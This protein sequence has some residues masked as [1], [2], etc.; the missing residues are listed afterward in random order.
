MNGVL[1]FRVMWAFIFILSQVSSATT[2]RD[3]V[4][5]KPQETFSRTNLSNTSPNILRREMNEYWL[6]KNYFC[7]SS[8]EEILF[9]ICQMYYFGQFSPYESDVHTIMN[10]APYL[11]P[12]GALEGRMK[13]DIAEDCCKKRCTRWAIKNQCKTKLRIY[14]PSNPK[15]STSTSTNL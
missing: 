2:Q 7:G 13:R 3:N 9:D 12:M 15:P 8:W 6:T 4:E 1:F 11:G 10:I 14:H 5:S